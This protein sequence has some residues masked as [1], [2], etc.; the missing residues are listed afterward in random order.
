MRR[1]VLQIVGAGAGSLFLLVVLVWLRAGAVL[2][3]LA[4]PIE[5]IGRQISGWMDATW[6]PQGGGWFPDLARTIMV[7]AVLVWLYLW[8][9]LIAVLRLPV[10]S[11]EK[12]ESSNEA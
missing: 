8:L 5:W 6:P 12:K 1:W 2:A 7:D 10:L 3:T 9:L 11:R 4:W